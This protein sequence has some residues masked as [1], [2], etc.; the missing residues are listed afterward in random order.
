M[1]T[2]TATDV[3]T[4]V[5]DWLDVKKQGQAISISIATVAPFGAAVLGM[6]GGLVFSYAVIRSCIALGISLPLSVRIS[7]LA[8][9]AI[10]GAVLCARFGW[11]LGVRIAQKVEQSFPPLKPVYTRRRY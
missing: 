7:I 8:P 2:K 5:V 3:Y 9:S 10:G 11:N 1:E 4:R 6:T